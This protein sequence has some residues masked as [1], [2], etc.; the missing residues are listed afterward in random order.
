MNVIGAH[1]YMGGFV[2]GLIQAGW[3]SLG[4]V[5]VWKEPQRLAEYLGV[6]HLDLWTESLPKGSVDLVVG[7]PPC[8]RFSSASQTAFDVHSK[9]NLCAFED[10]QFILN[11]GKASKAPVVWWEN[12]P[13]AYTSGREMIQ[14]AHDFIGAKVTVVLKFG[15]PLTG[16]L[17]NRTRTHVFHIMNNAVDYTQLAIP[18][19][20]YQEVPVYPWIMYNLDERTVR[21]YVH[22]NYYPMNDP[23]STVAAQWGPQEKFGFFATK[24]ICINENQRYVPGV[25]SGRYQ[26]W[27][28]HNRWWSI[29]EYA[30]A[31]SYP[32]DVD[33]EKIF[34]LTGNKVLTYMSKS[35]APRASEWLAQYFLPQL[36]G[37]RIQNHPMLPGN[38][39]VRGDIMY[40]RMMAVGKNKERIV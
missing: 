6:K 35:V 7:N 39:E 26:A 34:G 18:V 38:P 4:S 40:I 15:M 14:Q 3:K 1:T 21:P 2:R 16:A 11:L 24:P 32:T 22:E 27:E 31:M 9:T 29:A 28:N 19:S 23:V 5:E 30:S 25:V 37:D 13:L 17:Q 20:D 8:S 33:W 12:G 36:Y 10:L